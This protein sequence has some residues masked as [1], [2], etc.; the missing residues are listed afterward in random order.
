MVCTFNLKGKKVKKSLIVVG[1][2]LMSSMLHAE[3]MEER[4]DLTPLVG[5]DE[6]G[7]TIETKGHITIWSDHPIRPSCRRSTLTVDGKI[8]ASHEEN[9]DSSN[10]PNLAVNNQNSKAQKKSKFLVGTVASTSR[11][12]AARN[13]NVRIFG[14]HKWVM[15]NQTNQE[16]KY[17]LKYRVCVTV[18]STYC[19]SHEEY[20]PVPANTTTTGTAHHDFPYYASYNGNYPIFAITE[21]ISPE[22]SF[23]RDNKT[24]SVREHIS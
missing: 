19:S 4:H 10:D 8:I 16:I 12:G 18:L 9:C 2:V 13:T 7:H 15:E 14:H 11:V 24:L 5:I 20:I 1:L 3:V 17:R 23:A 22:Q 21:I 6:E